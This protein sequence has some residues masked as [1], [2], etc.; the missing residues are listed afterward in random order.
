MLPSSAG[1]T[2]VVRPLTWPHDAAMA[3]ERFDG[4]IDRRTL[5]KG[6]AAAGLAALGGAV[7]GCTARGPAGGTPRAAAPT[8]PP[9]HPSAGSTPAPLPASSSVLPAGFGWGAATSAYQVEGGADA[10]GKGPSVWDVFAHRGGTIADGSTGDVAADH[11]HRYADDI[12]LMASLGI[13]SYRFSVSWPRVLPDGTG[14]VNQRGL[15]FYKRLVEGLR[16]HDI[17]PVLTLWHWDTPQALQEKGGWENRDTARYFA[18]YAAVMQEALGDSVGLWLTLNEPKTVVE[19][20]YIVGAHAPGK[21]DRRAAYTAAHTL[22]L[23][24]GLAVAALRAAGTAGDVG[25]ALNVA[26]VYPTPGDDAAAV[27]AAT[28]RDGY[29]NRLYLDAV[30]RGRYPDDVLADLAAAGIDLHGLARSG[31]LEAIGA[32]IDVL[33]LNYYT[34]FVVDTAGRDVVRY[35]V[36]PA[37]WVQIYPEGLYDIVVRVARDYG[38]PRISITENGVPTQDAPGAGGVVDDEPRISYLHDH[39]AAM[40]RARAAGVRIEGFHVWSLLDNFE[41][42]AGYT[43]RW[44]I[45][46]VDFETQQRTPKASAAW[47]ADVIAAN[48]VV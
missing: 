27:A 6:A 7:A 17:E 47:Y 35:P 14:K 21:R 15:D 37:G 25:I 24:H 13:R 36:S 45:T 44:G 12:A 19:V 38:S 1:P 39:L 42:A 32:P 18:D 4:S 5:L 10:D 26:P 34:P 11:Y 46:R 40:Q 43:Q 2:T 23:G 16:R 22:L 20:G 30:F 29:E 9:T 31:D 48:G 3:A 33:G 41:W 28:L 8:S